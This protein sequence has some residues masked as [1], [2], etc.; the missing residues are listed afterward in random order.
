MCEKFRFAWVSE[1]ADIFSRARLDHSDPS[2]NDD[3]RLLVVGVV[4]GAH[5]LRCRGRDC[6]AR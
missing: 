1:A 5:V 3:R 4:V 2:S 6:C